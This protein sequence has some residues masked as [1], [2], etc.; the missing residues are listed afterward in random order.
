[1]VFADR[2]PL[3]LEVNK[4]M[5]DNFQAAYNATEHLI[6]QGCKRIAHFSGAAHRNIY[7]QRKKGY[8]AAL[9]NHGHGNLVGS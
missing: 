8:L 3:D 2:V 6:L 4:I 9:K 7:K 1:M 5:I